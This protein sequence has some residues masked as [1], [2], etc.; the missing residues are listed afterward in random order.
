MRIYNY[1]R[2]IY[3]NYK[4]EKLQEF[5]IKEGIKE[6]HRRT[7]NI[8]FGLEGKAIINDDVFE[9]IHLPADE[10]GKINIA[11]LLGL[12]SEINPEKAEEYLTYSKQLEKLRGSPSET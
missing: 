6:A 5:L 2:R 8:Q 10:K 9:T 4:I 11:P 1:L 3:L 12:A 7:K